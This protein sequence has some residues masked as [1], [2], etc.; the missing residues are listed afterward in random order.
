[1]ISL[2]LRPHITLLLVGLGSALALA[3]ALIAQY[4]FG[5]KPCHLCMLQRWPHLAVAVLGILGA[6]RLK[7][8]YY[9]RSLLV[10]CC[11]L[12]LTGSSIAI[13]HTG[14][15]QRWFPGPTG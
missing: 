13:Y 2:P 9:L 7:N 5:F 4:G 14:V 15:E 10:A 11:L 6:S 3:L 8:I 1:M 12:L